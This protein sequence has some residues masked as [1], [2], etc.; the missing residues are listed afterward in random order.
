[1]IYVMGLFY[2]HALYFILLKMVCILLKTTCHSV[3]GYVI[4]TLLVYHW[5][6]QAFRIA[7]VFRFLL[8]YY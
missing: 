2:N 4:F 5:T 3:W 1:M 6:K 7:S 8:Q